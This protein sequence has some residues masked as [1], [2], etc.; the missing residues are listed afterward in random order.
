MGPV[1][2]ETLKTGFGTVQLKTVWGFLNQ[3]FVSY[4]CANSAA[5]Q[6]SKSWLS[7]T[8]Q[9][10]FHFCQNTPTRASSWFPFCRGT[11]QGVLGSVTSPGIGI[12]PPPQGTMC[13]L[14]AVFSCVFL[15]CHNREGSAF[16]VLTSIIP[17]VGTPARSTKKDPSDRSFLCRSYKQFLGAKWLEV[18]NDPSL[19]KGTSMGVAES[20]HLAKKSRGEHCEFHFKKKK[21]LVKSNNVRMTATVIYQCQIR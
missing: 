1:N 18:T 16:W 3:R 14:S 7:F 2:T 17:T 21:N 10:T 15:T 11:E 4:P 12:R 20:C 8:A 9:V 5:G 13:G 6:T 19:L